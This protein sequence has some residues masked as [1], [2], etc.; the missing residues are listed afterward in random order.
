MNVS[1]R[2][3][4]DTYAE[5]AP[6]PAKARLEQ[7]FRDM[8]G[9]TITVDT[10]RAQ[11]GRFDHRFADTEEQFADYRNDLSTRL[12]R[13]ER[14]LTEI[15]TK[16]D[17]TIIEAAEVIK[18]E[19]DVVTPQSINTD[20]I[21]TLWQILYSDVDNNIPEA[22]GVRARMV[23]SEAEDQIENCINCEQRIAEGEA[24]AEIARAV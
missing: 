19:R 8:R 1:Q 3:H 11:R 14:E 15:N 16:I 18:A 2:E 13:A 5:R 20:L 17:D 23:L 10:K 24:D 9:K 7:L 12:D 6:Q 4:A 21:D 22:L